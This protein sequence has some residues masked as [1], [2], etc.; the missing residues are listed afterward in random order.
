MYFDTLIY[1]GHHVVKVLVISHVTQLYVRSQRL[2]TTA[3]HIA[4]TITRL[5]GG[6]WLP[7]R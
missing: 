4:N 1:Q 3:L 6:K 5:N 2:I 7:L